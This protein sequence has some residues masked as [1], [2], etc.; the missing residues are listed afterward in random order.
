[1]N[2]THNHSQHYN[3]SF[4]ADACSQFTQSEEGWHVVETKV[5]VRQS[6]SGSNKGPA[7]NSTGY[8]DQLRRSQIL[9]SKNHK[10]LEKQSRGFRVLKSDPHEAIKS[11]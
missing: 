11:T 4:N 3:G 9:S 6:A 5:R 8:Q 10:Y 7:Q 1:M 2:P